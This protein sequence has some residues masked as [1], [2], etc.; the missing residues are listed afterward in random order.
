MKRQ[1]FCYFI[2]LLF[3]FWFSSFLFLILYLIST[4]GEINGFKSLFIIDIVL[5]APLIISMFFSTFLYGTPNNRSNQYTIK[6][7]EIDLLRYNNYQIDA[8]FEEK[9]KN[10]ILCFNGQKLTFNLSGWFNQKQRLIDL[11]YIQCHNYYFNLKSLKDSKYLK[12]LIK[13]KVKV[14]FIKNGKTVTKFL[15]PSFILKMK[16]LFAIQQ[17]RFNYYGNKYSKKTLYDTYMIV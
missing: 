6:N 9:T 7:P 12:K 1:I 3:I 13:S 14:M 17:F 10:W 11:M 5:I 8:Y 4:K 16:M 15:K 2:L